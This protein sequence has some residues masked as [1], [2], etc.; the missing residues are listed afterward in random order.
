DLLNLA[1]G[2]LVGLKPDL[3]N[4]RK[5]SAE[6]SP[7]ADTHEVFAA[8]ELIHQV[9]EEGGVVIDGCGTDE[10]PGE[11]VLVFQKVG[12]G[13]QHQPALFRLRWSFCVFKGRGK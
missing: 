12:V 6:A 4:G 2:V 1:D 5:G 11:G 10:V 9:Q 3:L 8:S 7:G 13:D